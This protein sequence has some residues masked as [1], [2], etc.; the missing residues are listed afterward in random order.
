MNKLNHF[1]F[2]ASI[3][4]IL[5]LLDGFS[6]MWALSLGLTEMNPFVAQFPVWS[7]ISIQIIGFSIAYSIFFYL[8]NIIDRTFIK[9]PIY[10]IY[11][12]WFVTG[13]KFWVVFLNFVFI[14][15]AL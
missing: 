6:T 8:F 12:M 15:G 7:L 9:D 3:F 10:L 1:W 5:S 4:F 14:G 2:N 11:L 13:I